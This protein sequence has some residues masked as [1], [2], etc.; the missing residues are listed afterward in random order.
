MGKIIKILLAIPIDKR[1]R[2]GNETL[3]FTGKRKK[4][5][6]EKKKKKEEKIK[7][8]RIH[9]NNPEY[10]VNS[11][12]KIIIEKKPNNLFSKLTLVNLR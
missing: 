10:R 4:K 6:Q 9:A 3:Y 2:L 8:P 12:N 11:N 1:T 5:K 7:L